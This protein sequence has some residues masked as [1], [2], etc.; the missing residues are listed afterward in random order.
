MPKLK[1]EKDL[2]IHSRNF[3]K[4]VDRY[5]ERLAKEEVDEETKKSCVWFMKG[6]LRVGFEITMERSQK[7]T[8]DLYRCYE[9]FSEYYPE[10]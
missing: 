5:K 9:T 7:Y 6:L 8:R 10:K 1:V 4:R 3:H 2:A